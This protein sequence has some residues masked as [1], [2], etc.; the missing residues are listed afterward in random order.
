M[1]LGE[2]EALQ[3]RARS[4]VQREAFEQCGRAFREKPSNAGIALETNEKN[5]EIT[6]KFLIYT[7]NKSSKSRAVGWGS[8]RNMEQVA[9][10]EP[11]TQGHRDIND[12]DM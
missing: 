10:I 1:F 8:D 4:Q 6:H 9:Q 2:G 7:C 5:D 11:Y 12:P 3:V